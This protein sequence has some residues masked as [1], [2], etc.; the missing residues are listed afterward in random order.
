MS[1]QQHAR[2]L[3]YIAMRQ[4]Q[5]M[6]QLGDII[7]AVNTGTEWEGELRL[8]DLVAFAQHVEKLEGMLRGLAGATVSAIEGE[9]HGAPLDLRS[10]HER[11][12]KATAFLEALE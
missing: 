2:L 12:R 6:P 7:H 8:S 10:T 3:N 11:A 4:A 5:P 1:K 9:R